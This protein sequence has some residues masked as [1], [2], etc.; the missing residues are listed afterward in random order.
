MSLSLLPCD[1]LEVHDHI[2]F[3]AIF[4]ILYS[5]KQ[6]IISAHKQITESPASVGK[7]KQMFVT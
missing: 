2:F 6:D 1:L 7:V 5:K 4:M 3:R